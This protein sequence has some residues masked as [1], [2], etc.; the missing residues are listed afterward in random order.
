MR[1]NRWRRI[2]SITKV[3]AP[4]HKIG[5]LQYET[6]LV[7]FL[8]PH[9]TGNHFYNKSHRLCNN[10]GKIPTKVVEKFNKSS[11]ASPQSEVR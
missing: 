5:E 4:D 9:K 8:P 7:G 6:K 3:V 10:S 2:I 1:S 11:K